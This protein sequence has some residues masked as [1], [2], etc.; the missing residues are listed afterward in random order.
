MKTIVIAACVLVVGIA[1]AVPQTHF[2]GHY[3]P[4]PQQLYGAYATHGAYGQTASGAYPKYG[5]YGQPAS[6][7]YA[8]RVG[9]GQPASGA[10]AGRGGYGQ[11]VARAYA[12][13]G[14]YGQPAS[15]AY[16]GHRA[17]PYGQP[18]VTVYGQKTPVYGQSNGKAQSYGHERVYTVRDPYNNGHMHVKEMHVKMDRKM[19]ADEA[20]AA[21]HDIMGS[22]H[23][24]QGS[25]KDILSQIGF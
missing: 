11:P 22:M 21:L 3:A 25:F 12:G 17:V 16:A 9:Y 14:A 1:Y 19:N 23:G 10:Y 13:H 6:G 20:E 15:G 5:V 2:Y 24:G 8:G 7:A 18:Q 4:Q